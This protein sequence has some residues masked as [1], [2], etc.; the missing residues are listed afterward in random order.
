MKYAKR[1]F[2]RVAYER[3]QA[4]WAA[5]EA[6]HRQP[7][8]WEQ[9]LRLVGRH[10]ERRADFH[11]QTV[12]GTFNIL[13]CLRVRDHGAQHR[14]SFYKDVIL[15]MPCLGVVHFP[16]EKILAEA[17]TMQLVRAHCPDIPIPQVYLTGLSDENPTGLGPFILM[18]HVEHIHTLSVAICDVE[19]LG[20]PDDPRDQ[21]VCLDTNVPDEVLTVAWDQVAAHLLQLYTNMEFPCIGC[22]LPSN[23]NR[24][25][26]SSRNSQDLPLPLRFGRPITTNMNTLV[27]LAG[28]P[29]AVLPPPDATYQTS[30]DWYV[31]L[32]DM[33]MAHLVFQHNDLVVSRDDCRNKYVARQVFRRLATEGKLSTFGFADDT[34]SAQAQTARRNR[35]PTHQQPRPLARPPYKYGPFHLWCDGLHA[36]NFLADRQLRI[37]GVID[38]E[39]AYAGPTQF[40]L[41]PPWWL[42]LEPPESW[43]SDIWEWSSLY[44]DRL[45]GWLRSMERA[46]RNAEAAAAAATLRSGGGGEIDDARAVIIMAERMGSRRGLNDSD[47]HGEPPIRLSRYMRE[48]WETGRFWLNYAARNSWAFDYIYWHFLDEKF[49]GKR[50]I[51]GDGDVEDHWWRSRI[52]LLGRD[53]FDVMNHLADV[54]MD[55]YNEG[56]I[57]NEWG[58]QEARRHL[59]QFMA[60]V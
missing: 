7:E 25:A 23:L 27:D 50:P 31:A 26:S 19:K 14:H 12:R 41:D 22:V 38:W 49:F 37:N 48:S 3:S 51:D 47:H 29:A 17:T 40:S 30:D 6:M 59:A 39:F 46:E 16:D 53:H 1:S 21:S 60:P 56:N 57:N 33:H 13:Y 55:E 35:G 15:R 32:A 5:V 18:D 10:F 36:G 28:V 4:C 58:A 45:R 11:K 24:S 20:E 8:N 43:P 44:E 54:K 34:W 2:D 42:L 52:E 9:L